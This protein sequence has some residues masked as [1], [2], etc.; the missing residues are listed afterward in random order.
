MRDIAEAAKKIEG[1]VIEWRRELHK[2]PELSHDL[3]K[4]V[5]FIVRQLESIGVDSIARDVGILGKGVKSCGIVA[6]IIGERAGK[7]LAI[8]ADM[9]ALPVKE[10]VDLPFASR[11]GNMHACGHDAH[12]AM[13]LGVAELLA[14]RRKELSGK[15]RFI[16]QPAEE[17]MNGASSM[18]LDG[19]MD[20]VETIIGIHTG[21][22]WNQGKL[23]ALGFRTGGLMASSDKFSANFK[24]KGG[25]GAIPHLAVDP[26]LMACQAVCQLQSLVS[27]EVSPVS[28]AVVTVSMINGGSAFNI[29]PDTVSINGTL[30]TLDPDLRK[31]LQTRITETIEG[32]A[33]N[34]RGEAEVNIFPGCE[35]VIND[36]EVVNKMVSIAKNVLGDDMVQEISEPTMGGEDFSVF[37]EKAKGA[38][39][40]HNGSFGDER[41]MPHHNPKFQLNESSLWSGVA[42]M[43]AFALSWQ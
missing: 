38:F 18:V 33:R 15:V 25:H 20:G 19:A 27:R 35:A 1:K 31:F 26:V 21:T 28:P 41:D 22:L 7:T 39:F 14:D 8:R 10:E 17:T 3:P 4:T 13:L 11:N 34:M 12:V 24:G 43:T 42:A 30:R 40:F 2:I 16:F 37:L 29:I 23:G 5:E 32:V 9:D 6:E 36:K